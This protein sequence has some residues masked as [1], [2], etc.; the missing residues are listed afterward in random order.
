MFLPWALLWYQLVLP[1]YYYELW[2]AVDE[3]AESSCM[4]DPE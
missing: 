3:G 2:V 4:R 1:P